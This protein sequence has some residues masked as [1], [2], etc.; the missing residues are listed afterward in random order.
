MLIL[1]EILFISS[2]CMFISLMENIDKVI[3][4]KNDT[5]IHANSFA[6]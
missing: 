4:K 5:F 1:H 6:V 2:K 3:K